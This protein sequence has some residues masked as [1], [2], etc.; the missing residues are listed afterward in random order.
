MKSGDIRGIKPDFMVKIT[1]V[2]LAGW[3]G[4]MK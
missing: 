3:N 1:R 2:R 4:K